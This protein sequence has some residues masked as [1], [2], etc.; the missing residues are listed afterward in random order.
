MKNKQFLILAIFVPMLALKAQETQN[1]NLG[2]FNSIETSGSVNVIYTHSDTASLT[3]KAKKDELENIETKFDRGI[4]M[5]KNRGSFFSPVYVYV[6]NNRLISLQ[7]SGSSAFKTTNTIKE[8]SFA[9]SVSGT[10]NVSLMLRT[11]K[12]KSLQSGSSQLTLSGSTDKLLAELSGASSLKAYNLVSKNTDITATG[13]SS[14]RIFVMDKLRA[15]A[16]GASSIKVRGEVTDIN[17][18]AGSAASIVRISDNGKKNDTDSTELNF[19]RRKVIITGRG[20]GGESLCKQDSVKNYSKESAFKHWCGLFIGVNGY[21][22]SDGGITLSN[23]NKY[24]DLNYGRS[25]NFQLNLFE[26]QFNI[27]SNNL[28]LVTGFGFDFH[29]YDLSNRTNLDPDSSFTFGSIDATAGLKFRKNR[30]RCTYIQIPLLLEFNTRNN[31]LRTFHLAFGIVGQYLVSSR[32]KQVLEQQEY[33]ITKV[34]KDS[35]NL[36]PFAAKAH[37]NFGYKRW[38]IYAEYSLT[39][40][41]QSGKGVELYPFSAGLRVL[42]FG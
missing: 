42:P 28:K 23:Q 13:A 8:D 11:G 7:S 3:V 1:R 14:S 2:I 41:F 10:S 25:F 17:A 6:K 29:S 35:Y 27:I 4:L 26:R 5:I 21:L 22:G 38:T 40:L 9:V 30:L 39:P 34:R 12:V 36:S 16:S 18:E 19:G 33:E 31:P 20:E 32:T 15:S 24:M 37:V